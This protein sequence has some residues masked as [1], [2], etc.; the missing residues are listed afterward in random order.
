MNSMELLIE[1]PTPAFLNQA[2]PLLLEVCNKVTE[3]F[4]SSKRPFRIQADSLHP[5]TV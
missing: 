5:H 3:N 2:K 1:R 4:K